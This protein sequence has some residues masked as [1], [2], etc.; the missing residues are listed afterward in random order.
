MSDNTEPK[1]V[2]PE[3][4]QF[5]RIAGLVIIILAASA[6]SRGSLP[7]V[8]LEGLANGSGF[9]P[10]YLAGV[11]ALF[12]FVAVV[13][14]Q[15]CQTVLELTNGAS[16]F[17]NKV[18]N[19]KAE[20]LE[21]EDMAPDEM[22]L[23]PQAKQEEMEYVQRQIDW[24]R[25][26]CLSLA[27]AAAMLGLQFM[28][29]S[30]EAMGVVADGANETFSKS[31]SFKAFDTVT[32]ILLLAGGADRFHQII[33]NGLPDRDKLLSMKAEQVVGAKSS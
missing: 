21:S 1:N 5:T 31:Q 28:T 7:I 16:T 25:L 6:A 18:Q 2:L 30:F 14:E 20:M 26:V 23:T 29:L 9:N 24:S 12:I 17:R 3:P 13:I 19:V 22:T 27:A 8:K 11:L 32:T 33:N 4:N 10:V 15:A